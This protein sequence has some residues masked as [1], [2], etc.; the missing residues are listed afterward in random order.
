MIIAIIDDEKD[1]L[2]IIENKIKKINFEIKKYTSIKD[3]ED[4]QIVFDL[5]L[6]DIEMPDCNGLLYAKN[7]K[8]KNIIFI[9]NHGESIKDAFGSNVYGFIEK[10]DDDQRYV[11]VIKDAIDEIQNQKYIS[12]KIDNTEKMFILNDIVYIQCYMQRNISFV[13]HKKSYNLKGYTLKELEKKLNN[14]FVYIDRGTLVNKDMI[15][16]LIGNSLYVKD[17]RQVFS[18]SRRRIA[19]IKRLIKEEKS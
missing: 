13:Y 18:V 11:Q 12:L 14:Q 8:D 9:S 19:S 7:N 6:L 16:K 10:T 1:I 17:I 4:D 5:Y 15:L 3:M 2:D